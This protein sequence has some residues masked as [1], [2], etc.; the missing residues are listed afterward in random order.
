MTTITFSLLKSTKT[1]NYLYS[2][3]LNFQNL[4]ETNQ[5]GKSNSALTLNLTQE[6]TGKTMSSSSYYEYQQPHEPPRKSLPKR[7]L[8]TVITIAIIIP[9]VIVVFLE[10][11]SALPS[12]IPEI[13]TAT[14]GIVDKTDTL[15]P[16]EI[17]KIS[18]SID[19]RPTDSSVSQIGVLMVK[20]PPTG[21]DIEKASLEV[22]RKWGI[23]SKDSKNGVLLYIAKEAGQVRIETADE[24]G[25]YLIDAESARII[26][27]VM[28]PRL[29]E[30]DFYNGINEGVIAIRASVSGKTNS[31]IDSHINPD[32]RDKT[33]AEDPIGFI[34]QLILFIFISGIIITV[35]FLTRKIGGNDSSSSGGGFFGGG[36]GFSGGGASGRF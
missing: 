12:S 10:I 9:I 36:G 23:G 33:I 2:I 14:V 11:S 13:P 24:S 35:I 8:S 15:S 25:I 17:D 7:I 32:E 26:R 34:I 5:N 31:T 20:R 29:K 28:V 30:K 19:N 16:T 6:N 1:T 4:I 18:K 21:K 3:T 27:D 22:A